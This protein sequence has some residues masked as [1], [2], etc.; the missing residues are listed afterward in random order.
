MPPVLEPEAV[1]GAGVVLRPWT[2]ADAPALLGL[3]D[4]EEARIFSPLPEMAADGLAGA[5]AWC[6]SRADWSGGTHASWA[7]E[8][9]GG[10][11]GY[12]SVFELDFDQLDGEVG[13]FVLPGRRRRGVATRAVETAAG[14]AFGRLGLLRLM[15]YHAVENVASCAIAE[16]SGFRLEGV[17][18]QSFRYGDGRHHDEHS[19]GRLAGDRPPAQPPAPA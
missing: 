19:H 6:E 11:A 14:Y 9:D 4:D 1:T 7:V 2:V 13:Y 10:L 16:R 3:L 15:L 12:V 18:R 5:V 17:H 8:L